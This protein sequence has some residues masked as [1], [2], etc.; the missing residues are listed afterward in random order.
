MKKLIRVLC[1]LFCV[2]GL[3]GCNNVADNTA[4]TEVVSKDY[5]KVIELAKAEFNDIFKEIEDIQ[6]EETTTMARTDDENEIVVQIKYSSKNGSGV[7]GFVY[8]LEDAANP[9]LIQH[10]EHVNI[11]NLLQ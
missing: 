9:E 5:G 6:I 8:N 7:Y 2:I 11:D 1:V 10:G 4:E 3:V